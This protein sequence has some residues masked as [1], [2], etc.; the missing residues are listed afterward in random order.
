MRLIIFTYSL[1]LCSVIVAQTKFLHVDQFG[2]RPDAE[3]ILVINNPMEGFNAMES[4]TPSDELELVSIA[5]NQVVYTASPV[6]WNNGQLMQKAYLDFND[7]W[8]NNSWEISE[9]AIY[10]QAGYVRLLAAFVSASDTP[11]NVKETQ[12]EG[13]SWFPNPGSDVLRT[14]HRGKLEVRVYNTMGTLVLQLMLNT[15]ASI[16]CSHLPVGVYVIHAS[17]GDH[18]FKNKWIKQ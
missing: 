18:V 1:L 16:D 7:N 17:D 12:I 9:R 13:L 3:K 2:Y 11:D 14:S 15:G 6:A 4:Y 10:Y 5:T 8:P